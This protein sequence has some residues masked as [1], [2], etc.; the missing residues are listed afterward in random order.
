[1]IAISTVVFTARKYSDLKLLGVS[2]VTIVRSKSAD[3]TLL[4]VCR[5]AF[6]SRSKYSDPHSWE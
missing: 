2:T 6:L 1:M 5:S 4:G 3:F